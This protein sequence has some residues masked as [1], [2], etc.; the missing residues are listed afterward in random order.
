MENMAR[1]NGTEV[2]VISWKISGC[3][4]IQYIS[5]NNCTNFEPDYGKFWENFVINYET[6]SD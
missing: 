1:K 3:R 2:F 5:L 4:V 6:L